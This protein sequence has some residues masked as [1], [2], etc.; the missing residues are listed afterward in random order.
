[1]NGKTDVN[2]FFLVCSFLNLNVSSFAVFFSMKF[3]GEL[4]HLK[5]C[6]RLFMNLQENN[7]TSE[8]IIIIN[9][10]WQLLCEVSSR[11]ESHW[12]I[13]AEICIIRNTWNESNIFNF[14]WFLHYFIIEFSFMKYTHI[15]R[16][17]RLS[18]L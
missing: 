6:S 16:N 18:I 13:F 9:N 8:N 11:R 15:L 10:Y 5:C 2:K 1:M 7:H 14:S 12:K 4:Q 17:F 3:Q